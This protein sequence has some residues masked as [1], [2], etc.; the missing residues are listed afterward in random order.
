[1]L[2]K[3]L[4]VKQRAV[5]AV[6]AARLADEEAKPGDL[7]GGQD[8]SRLRLIGEQGLDE[9]VESG[10]PGHEATLERRD[11]L[12][13]VHV[14]LGH[15]VA[16]GGGHRLPVRASVEVLDR[17]RL[18]GKSRAV[19]EVRQR[20]E[21][22]LVLGPVVLR[23]DVGVHPAVAAVLSRVL[24][25]SEGLGPL[26]VLAPVPEQPGA[27]RGADDG[28]R[29]A[30]RLG[31]AAR[32]RQPIG[33]VQLGLVAAR[34]RDLAVCAEA[35]VGEDRLAERGGGRVV[36]EPVGRVDGQLRQAADP[37]RAQRVDLVRGE[38]RHRQPG[39]R[40]RCGTSAAAGEQADGGQ[41][42]G[43]V[44]HASH[45]APMRPGGRS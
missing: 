16:I 26:A 34:T 43:E 2:W 15:R 37:E 1:M 29:L 20:P 21:D 41:R 42:P 10:R 27:V 33:E 23:D 9:G 40:D 14:D 5:V 39:G 36:R 3:L 25:R 24:H 8:A 22:R 18:V 31:D 11:R 32:S 45:A 17:A 35:R 28:H 7:V 6:R 38:G 44:E 4:F 19:V 13:D 12:A 30:S